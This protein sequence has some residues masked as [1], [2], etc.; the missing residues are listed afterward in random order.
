MSRLQVKNSAVA[1]ATLHHFSTLLTVGR[2]ERQ[3]TV[4]DLS[5][6]VG[7]SKPT[8]LKILKGDPSVS[9]GHY[10]ET[11]WVLGVPLF[12]P[13]ESRFADKRKALKKLDTLLPSRVRAKKVILDDNF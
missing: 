2:K 8:M 13:D 11:A 5:S 12:E 7:V 4:D 1:T 10:F 3:F 6:R 9:I